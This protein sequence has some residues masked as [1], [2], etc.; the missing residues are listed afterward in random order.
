MGLGLGARQRAAHAE[1]ACVLEP[2][3]LVAHG[4]GRVR[5]RGRGRVRVGVGVGVGVGA[6]IKSWGWGAKK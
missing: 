6:R 2:G 3:D 4:L 5:G 1:V